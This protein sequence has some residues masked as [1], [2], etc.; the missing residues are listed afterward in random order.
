MITIPLLKDVIETSIVLWTIFAFKIFG[1][2]Y[3][4][5]AGGCGSDPSPGIRNLSVQLYLTAFGKRTPINRLAYASAMAIILLLL[6]AILIYL[7]RKV[8]KSTEILEY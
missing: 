5:G 2:I 1:Y 7:I 8:F 4:F 3:A 6:V